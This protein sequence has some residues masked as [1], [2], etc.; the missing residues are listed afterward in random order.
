MAGNAELE[1]QW[2]GHDLYDVAGEKIGTIEDVRFGEIVGNLTWLVV[3]TG[4]LGTHRIYVPAG[5]VQSSAGKLV[6][7]YTKGRVKDAPHVKD[8]LA[9][10]PEVEE[11][12]CHYYGLDYVRS[13]TEPVEGCVEAQGEEQ[14]S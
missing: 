3:K 12:L 4:L 8:E 1:T 14:T 9:S 2:T 6:V 13:V 5:E 7:S 11:K 10:L